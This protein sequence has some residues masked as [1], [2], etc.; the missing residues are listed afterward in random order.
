MFVDNNCSQRASSREVTQIMQNES[1]VTPVTPDDGAASFVPATNSPIL[2]AEP[3]GR[4]LAKSIG[5]QAG[6]VNRRTRKGSKQRTRALQ[7]PLL[8]FT[9][10]RT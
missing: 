5:N 9:K 6:P 1:T 4:Q 3:P 7:R 2:P 10:T 8:L